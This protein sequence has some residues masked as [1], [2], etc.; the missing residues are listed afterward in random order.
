MCDLPHFPII[1]ANCAAQDVI[2]LIADIFTRYDRLVALHGC[3]KVVS[4]MDSYFVIGGVPVPSTDH[5]ARVLNLAM[6]FLMEA[7]QIKVPTLNLSVMV[8]FSFYYTNFEFQKNLD[9]GFGPFRSNSCR[10][11]WKDQN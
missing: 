9:S 4:M 6:G 7:K 3:Y 1:V 10:C 2:H 5:A 8:R 11:N